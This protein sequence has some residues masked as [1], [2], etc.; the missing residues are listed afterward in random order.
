MIENNE[1]EFMIRPDRGFEN[2][3]IVDYADRNSGWEDNNELNVR[4]HN[5]SVDGVLYINKSDKFLI[6]KFT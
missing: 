5:K 1:F 4:L 2:G 3:W 6:V